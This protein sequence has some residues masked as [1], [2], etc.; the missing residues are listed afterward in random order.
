VFLFDH[1][2]E[3]DSQSL[4]HRKELSDDGGVLV[5]LKVHFLHWL[6]GLSL[7]HKLLDGVLSIRKLLHYAQSKLTT[8]SQF[9][10]FLED[11]ERFVLSHRSI[12]ERAPLQTYGTALAFSPMRSEVEMQT[13]VLEGKVIIHIY[14]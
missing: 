1:L 2:C 4:D 9:V 10:G 8:S 7:I 6:E 3:I 13:A 12:I 11:A 5:F 14:L